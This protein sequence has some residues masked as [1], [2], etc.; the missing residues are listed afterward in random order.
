MRPSKTAG[1]PDALD[2]LNILKCAPEEYD[3]VEVTLHPHP[4]NT[5]AW[6]CAQGP[7][8]HLPPRHGL[9]AVTW[10]N[11]LDALAP[12]YGSISS[13]QGHFAAHAHA[14]TYHGVGD[15]VD[16]PLIQGYSSN[17]VSAE[18]HASYSNGAVDYYAG[19]Y[20]EADLV[21]NSSTMTGAFDQIAVLGSQTTAPGFNVYDGPFTAPN[22]P[23]PAFAG[24][25]L[26]GYHGQPYTNMS[27]SHHPNHYPGPV[28]SSYPPSIAQQ[29]PGSTAPTSQL[30]LRVRVMCTH[31]GCS[32]TFRGDPERIR[33]QDAVHGV[34]QLLQLYLCPVVGCAKS[35]GRGYTRKDKLTEHMWKKHG[36]LGFVKRT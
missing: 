24:P 20:N 32:N 3:R 19:C 34:N 33:H 18:D 8:T 30:Q 1:F 21:D 36:N 35:Q 14:A 10:D 7:F 27:D 28:P 12:A 17:Y 15:I 22:A 16:E 2:A 9:K 26:P 31:P 25:V 6:L 13:S 11:D 4:E 29:V 23:D 5:Y